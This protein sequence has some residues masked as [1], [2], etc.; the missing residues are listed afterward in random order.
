MK[1]HRYLSSAV[2]LSALFLS[3]CSSLLDTEPFGSYVTS[4]QK[5]DVVS[6]NPD[7]VSASVNGITT[8]FSVF[9]AVTGTSD[10]DHYDFGYPAIMLFMDGR[11]TDL[12]SPDIGYNWFAYGLDMLSDHRYNSTPTRLVWET[13]YNQIYAANQVISVM[14]AESEDSVSQF[15]LAQALA[16]RAF[17]YFHLAQIY[18]HTY[19][20]HE[21]DPCVPLILESNANEAAANGCARSSVQ[22]VYDQ[23][24]SDLDL[25]V[26]L[27]EKTSEKRADKR[28][29]NLS[30][31]LGLRA[32]VHLVMQHYAEAL[33]DASA[34]IANGD[35]VPKSLQDAAKPSFKELVEEDWLWGISIAETDRVVTSGIINWPSH[36]GSL[37]YGYASVGAWRSINKKLF[38]RIPATDVRKGWFLDENGFSANLSEEQQDYVSSA[39]CTPYTQ[40]KFAPYK[41]EIYTSTNANDIPLMRVEEMYLIKAEC[42]AQTGDAAAAAA[43]LNDFVGTYRDSAYAFGGS[44]KDAVLDEVYFQ[45]RVELWGEGIVY[46]D[47]LRLNKGFDRRGAGFEENYVFVIAPEDPILIYQIPNS[48]IQANKLLTEADNNPGASTP[49]PVPDL[50]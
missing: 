25:A 30:V 46:F 16:I 50:D 6:S 15:Y 7:M 43:T 31:A 34:V 33:A 36:M 29:V 38:A 42:E 44:S 21:T 41:D 8:M 10:P 9:G 17:D 20:G 12:V 49:A 27:L 37:N 32:R 28:Y 14:D 39:G 4:D 45:R 11:G 26:S 2:I 13:F 40:V 48:E 47:I 35:A 23:I 18:Q 22:E 1:L 24:L 5:E 3:G 19:K